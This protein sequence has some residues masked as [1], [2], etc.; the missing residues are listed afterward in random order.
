MESKSNQKYF[1]F[2][3]IFLV[4]QL[5]LQLGTYFADIFFLPP[6][7]TYSSLDVDSLV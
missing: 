7:R 3:P 5:Q 2:V 1:L 6:K 4:F